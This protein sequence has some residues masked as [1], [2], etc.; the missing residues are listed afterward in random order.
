MFAI[1]NKYQDNWPISKDEN[2]PPLLKKKDIF[3]IIKILSGG[4]FLKVKFGQI[5]TQ[6]L[7]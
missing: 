6:N 1:K 7:P 2:L 3:V 4:W 5:L